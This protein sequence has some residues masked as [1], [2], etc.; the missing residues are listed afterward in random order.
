VSLQIP[1]L[2]ERKNDIPILSDHFLRLFAEETGQAAKTLS[3]DAKKILMDYSWPGNVR[4]LMNTLRRSSV[5]ASSPV[6]GKSDLGLDEMRITETWDNEDSFEEF[7]RKRIGEI[8]SSWSNLEEGDLYDQLLAQLERPL[9]ELTM[10]AVK[11]N[12]VRAAKILGINRNTLR[13]RLRKYDLL[14][15]NNRET[16][17]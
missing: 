11:G 2:R 5:L 10:G 13:E 7:L 16:K 3:D 1:P 4:E 8:V 6:I 15:K 14:K 12:Q 9:F 17:A